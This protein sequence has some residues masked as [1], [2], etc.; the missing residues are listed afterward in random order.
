MVTDEKTITSDSVMDD[1][2]VGT[3]LDEQSN[4]LSSTT[5]LNNAASTSAID[6]PDG[7]AVVSDSHINFHT[8]QILKYA[9]L[10]Q[11]E[12]HF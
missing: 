5:S 7:K 8:Y 10:K 1:E 4:S 6:G 2:G 3:D 12:M 11:A 9:F